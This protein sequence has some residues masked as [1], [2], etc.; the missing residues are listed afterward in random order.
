MHDADMTLFKWL[1][2]RT[3]PKREIVTVVELREPELFDQSYIN[4]V[5]AWC[6]AKGYYLSWGRDATA[7]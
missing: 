1:I 3:D 5:L 7:Q 4:A 6:E 2:G